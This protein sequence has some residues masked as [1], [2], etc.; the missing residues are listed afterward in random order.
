MIYILG[1]KGR[2]NFLPACC[3]Q[4]QQVTTVH[5]FNFLNRICHFEC[6]TLFSRKIRTMFDTS[7]WYVKGELPFYQHVSGLKLFVLQRYFFPLP[8]FLTRS[9]QH[10]ALMTDDPRIHLKYKETTIATGKVLFSSEKMLI[11]F[12]FLHENICCG[13]LLEVAQW[14][15]S[16][17][18][19]T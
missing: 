3:W 19:T 12:L 11:S 6:Q 10:A 18:Y 1:T 7:T 8:L 9:R 5:W 2:N 13:Y 14:E 4:Y 15:A 16:N 17:E